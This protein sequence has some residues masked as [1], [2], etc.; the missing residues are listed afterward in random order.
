MRTA[1]LCIF[2]ALAAA[3]C[4]A[5]GRSDQTSEAPQVD[6]YAAQEPGSLATPTADASFQ[7]ID[8]DG[9][10]RFAELR[11][12]IVA[13]HK[14]CASV[15]QA[16]LLGGLQGTDEWRVKCADSGPWAVWLSEDQDPEVNACTNPNC[17]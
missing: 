11:A 14:Q 9:P 16:I 6:R 5:C 8:A 2:T 4:T 7:L 10:T 3:L 17:A 13:E 1:S 12:L 15:T